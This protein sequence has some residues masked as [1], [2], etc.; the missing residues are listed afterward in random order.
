MSKTTRKA[1]L[2]ALL[3]LSTACGSTV[4]LTSTSTSGGADQ[5][6]GPATGSTVDASQ[7]GTARTPQ[8]GTASVP[9]TRSGGQ[10]VTVA[11]G[12]AAAASAGPAAVA[13]NIPGV[14]KTTLTIGVLA[15]DPQ[16]NTTLENAGFGA[17]S[18]GDEP[19][20]WRAMADEANAHGGIAGR[21]LVM[22]FFLVN[23]TDSPATQGQAACEKFTQD[24]KVAMVLSGYYYASADTCLA[25]K[26]V[27]AFLGTNYGVDRTAA[28]RTRTVVAWATPLL[29][30][31]ATVLPGAF[32]RLGELKSGTS[33][34]I[35]VTDSA[36][37]RRS[38]ALLSSALTH[39]G[40]KVVTETVRDSDS[41][42]YS[43][44]ASDA[45]AAVLKF[46]SAG[47]TEVLFLS[48]NAFEPTLLMQA[49]NSQGYQPTYLLSTQQYPGSLVGLV[50]ASQLKGALAIGWAPAEDLTSG[51][52]SSPRAQECL[53]E[54]KRHGRTYSSPAQTLVGLLACDGVDLLKRAA[55]ATGGLT[56]RD[57]LQR[58]AI[59]AKGFV[60]AV[61]I[62]TAFPGGR[63]D[64]VAAYRPM[65]FGS[66][67]G[68]FR[69]T[70]PATGM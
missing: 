17:A 20:S 61:T 22:V 8:T 5:G 19:A 14:T 67:C 3:A 32:Q 64:G 70:G 62:K 23:L 63:R 27:P 9:S 1:W 40:V 46:R 49:A 37:F 53:R 6:L 44:A 54:L 18:L 66:D 36:P 47:V 58:N 25:Q 68:C 7:P 10:A 45:S 65:A 48:H 16:A 28:A 60:S 39:S 2:V 26:G 33:A 38:A 59:D 55:E 42:D 13:N 50:P 34:G 4:Q 15:A 43:G 35:F 30:R 31:L 51:Y 29:D 57:V 41:G 52:D 21:R 12:S 56:S 11:R 24:N 69:Y